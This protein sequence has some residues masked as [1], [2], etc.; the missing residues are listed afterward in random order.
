MSLYS[1]RMLVLIETVDLNPG[2][3]LG[4][5]GFNFGLIFFFG[6]ATFEAVVNAAVIT[7]VGGPVGGEPG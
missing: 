7:L 1:S 4:G 3:V 5:G 2:L 6:C